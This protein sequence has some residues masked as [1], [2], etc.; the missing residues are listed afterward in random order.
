MSE[1]HVRKLAAD[2]IT[3]VR[4][5][6]VVYKELSHRSSFLFE[7]VVPGERWGRYSI[8]GCL[9]EKEGAYV[10]DDPLGA[11]GAEVA[12]L[13]RAETFIE[14]LTQARVGWLTYEIVSA[15]HGLEAWDEGH[16]YA[17]VMQEP[18][19]LLFDNLEQTLTIAGKNANVVKRCELELRR[20]ADLVPMPVPDRSAAPEHVD[21][22]LDDAA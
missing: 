2:F 3:P 8:V 15:L 20:A 10:G 6:A 1:L 5:Y 13:P 21:L 19:I 16:P 17:R 22:S 14:A 18:T 9:P 12:A 4:A 7:S 11:L